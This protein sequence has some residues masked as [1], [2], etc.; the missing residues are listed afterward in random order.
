MTIKNVDIK[1][2]PFDLMGL[3]RQSCWRFRPN[4]QEQLPRV[5]EYSKALRFTSFNCF[6]VLLND[7]ADADCRAD[8]CADNH[9]YLCHSDHPLSIWRILFVKAVEDFFKNNSYEF[10]NIPNHYVSPPLT[11]LRYYL[12]ILPML[13]AALTNAPITIS[14]FAIQITPFPFEES[15][16][17]KLL[18][19][20]SRTIPTSSRIFQIIMF[21]LL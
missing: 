12:T 11:V 16:S 9:K 2:P 10:K 14:T 7:P 3:I 8:Q 18:K 5:Q 13:T 19:I 17:S 4:P 21:H 1:A 6:T 20:S 15:Y